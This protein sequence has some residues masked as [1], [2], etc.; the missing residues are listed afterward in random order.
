M[1]NPEVAVDLAKSLNETLEKLSEEYGNLTIKIDIIQIKK[2]VANLKIDIATKDGK[3]VIPVHQCYVM[4]GDTISLTLGG[5]K[6]RLKDIIK[7]LI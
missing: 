4:A 5:R 6:L 2:K 7:I 1:I 3:V